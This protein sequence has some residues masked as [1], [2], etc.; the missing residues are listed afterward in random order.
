MPAPLLGTCNNEARFS[1]L[2]LDNVWANIPSGG[3]NRTASNGTYVWRRSP[4][5]GNPRSENAISPGLCL[6]SG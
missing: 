6:G 2:A 5:L 3:G 1:L 4:T